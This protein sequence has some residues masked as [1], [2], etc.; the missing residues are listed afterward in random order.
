MSIDFATGG[1]DPSMVGSAGTG[2]EGLGFKL[3][4]NFNT[5]LKVMGQVM[6]YKGFIWN[7]EDTDFRV[8]DSQTDALRYWV[9]VFS[10]LNNYW[11]IRLKWTLDTG[12]PITNYTFEPDDPAN[13]Y[14]NQRISWATI[15]GQHSTSD[16]RLQLDYAF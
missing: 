15:T 7:F 2:S 6:L 13:Q 16:I 10:R 12:L 5:R 1:E 8:F 4:H 9:S 14:P 11:A 3:T